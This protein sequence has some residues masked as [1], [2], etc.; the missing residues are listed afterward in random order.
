[1]SLDDSAEGG[2][3][4]PAHRQELGAEVVKRRQQA[5]FAELL[6]GQNVLFGACSHQFLPKPVRGG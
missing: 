2:N 5:H 3:P 1:M 4:I 6:L